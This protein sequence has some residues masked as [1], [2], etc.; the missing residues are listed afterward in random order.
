[1]HAEGPPPPPPDTAAACAEAKD[2]LLE[3]LRLLQVESPKV[4]T[5]WDK[6][7][8]RVRAEVDT[9]DSE[10]LVGAGG[11][12]LES[13]QYLVTLMLTRRMKTPVAVQ[14]ETGG[15]WHEKEEDILRQV[16]QAME[17]VQRTSEPVRLSPMDACMRRLVH[18]TLANHPEFETI[19]EG[20][21]PFRKVVL[22]P[23]RRGR[24]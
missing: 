9:A 7:Q 20:E 21:G 14:V 19:S 11:R 17:M 16:H 22:K 6:D 2:L 24:G 12:T 10:R 4:A 18:R 23:R 5:G 15:Y 3:V 13:L 8:E 1:M